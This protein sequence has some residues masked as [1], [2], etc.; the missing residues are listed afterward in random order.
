MQSSFF[1]APSIGDAS[2]VACPASRRIMFSRARDA[3]RLARDAHAEREFNKALIDA[4]RRDT[5]R[6]EHDKKLALAELAAFERARA[7]EDAHRASPSARARGDGGEARVEGGVDDAG[8]DARR[9]EDADARADAAATSSASQM[10]AL[11][12][13]HEKEMRPLRAELAA[14]AASEAS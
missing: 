1:G 7:R 11:R 8:E 5:E 3:E 4:L 10:R 2:A 13:A 6:A 9:L 12:D 14:L